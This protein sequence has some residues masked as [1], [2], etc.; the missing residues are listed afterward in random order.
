MIKTDGFA[1]SL[2]AD[3]LIVLSTNADAP[4]PAIASLSVRYGRGISFLDT[5]LPF[6]VT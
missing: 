3:G 5:P 4:A 6:S 2:S 1:K